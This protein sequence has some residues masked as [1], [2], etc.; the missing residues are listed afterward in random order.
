MSK[1]GGPVSG[2][3]A[4]AVG[5]YQAG[6][7]FGNSKIVKKPFAKGMEKVTEWANNIKTE[8]KRNQMIDREAERQAVKK[9]GYNSVGVEVKSKI[10]SDLKKKMA[11]KGV[12]NGAKFWK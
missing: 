7:S 4:L 6:K 1:A 5:A 10:K 3:M 12:Y 11:S 8:Y 9:V 2:K